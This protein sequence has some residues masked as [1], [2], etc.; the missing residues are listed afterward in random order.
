MEFLSFHEYN[1]FHL[2]RSG[3]LWRDVNAEKVIF[4]DLGG[5]CMLFDFKQWFSTLAV[6][7]ELS[8]EL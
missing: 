2:C 7:L 1:N 3:S 8:G 5:T 4:I 6:Q